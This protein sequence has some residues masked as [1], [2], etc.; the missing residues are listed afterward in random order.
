MTD[1]STPQS[2]RHHRLAAPAIIALAL[3]LLAF[4][5]AVDASRPIRIVADPTPVA[6]VNVSRIFDEIDERSEWDIRIEAIR[7]SIQK[8]AAGRQA[9]M[10]RRLG[11]SE[12]APSADDRQRIRDEVAL[13]QLRFEQWATVKNQ[14]IDREESL[15]WRSIY[16]NM[17]REA[18]RVAEAEGY[19][20]VMI[21]DSI[22][23]IQTNAGTQTP[24]QQQVVEQI[25]N[26]RVL[27]ARETI[28]ISDQVIVRM[29]N[30][31]N[32]AP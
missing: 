26:R 28:D 22:G 24:L 17:K 21:N 15:K 6:V 3:V 25:M 1:V 13:M 19:A 32:A 8:E 9:A 30:A 14:E 29:N 10:E 7:A 18:A 11:E 5:I 2:L 31:A 23:E 20:M 12:S 27:F 16:R 4:S